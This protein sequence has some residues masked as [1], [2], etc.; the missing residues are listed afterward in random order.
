MPH[1]GNNLYTTQSSETQIGIAYISSSS[2]EDFLLKG[3]VC[4]VNNIITNQIFTK[5]IHGYNNPPSMAIASLFNNNFLIPYSD[6]Y[7]PGESNSYYSHIFGK[8]LL[9]YASKVSVNSL[10]RVA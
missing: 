3:I 2:N 10:L 7:H 4:S 1:Y 6:N 9:L 5:H 8:V